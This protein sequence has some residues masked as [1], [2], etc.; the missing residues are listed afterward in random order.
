MEII[1]K[2]PNCNISYPKRKVVCSYCKG[3]L[4]KYHVIKLRIAF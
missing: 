3:G 4:R 1:K 2:C